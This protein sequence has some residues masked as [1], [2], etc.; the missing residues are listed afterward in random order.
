MK[1]VFITALGL[2]LPLCFSGCKCNGPVTKTQA[3]MGTVVEISV[4][5]A[6]IS[7]AGKLLAVDK[8]FQRIKEIEGLMSLYNETSE[9]SKINNFADIRPVEVSNDT[10]KVLKRA[11]EISNITGGAFDITIAPLVD[12]W[13][14]GAKGMVLK[15]P[16]EA[17]IKEALN[18][19]GMD[20]IKIDYSR[21]TVRFLKN[22]VKIDLN[23]IA[24][25]YAVDCAIEI[26]K[27]N[28]IRNAMVN[29]GGEVMCIGNSNSGRPWKVGIQ[30]PRSKNEL[31][32]S[33]NIENKAMST[34]GDYENFFFLD[35]KHV[36]YNIDF[37]TG[38]PVV[39]SPA[40]VSV[41][42][43]DCMTADSLA[44][45]I[46]VL[47]VDKGFDILDKMASIE[48]MIVIDSVDNFEVYKTNG[49]GKSK[50]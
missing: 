7:E 49:F 47:G 42:A 9:I 33:V 25:G 29:A 31:L 38:R 5:G 41:T 12:L 21:K 36:S 32:T 8:A 30:H 35:K 39:N 20:K 4:C 34:S 28:G 2:I 48:A 11:D 24:Q 15:P 44:T 17:Q 13:G 26:L 3:F 22:G 10:I 40:S 27:D 45:A 6:N 16:D 1:K 46:F 50:K 18:L 43:P 19:V 23:G 37:R 14:F